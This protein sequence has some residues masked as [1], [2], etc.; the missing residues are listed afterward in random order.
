MQHCFVQTFEVLRVYHVRLL[1]CAG[2]KSAQFWKRGTQPSQDKKTTVK[3]TTAGISQ[4]NALYFFDEDLLIQSLDKSEQDRKQW[5]LWAGSPSNFQ[6][7]NK[8]MRSDCTVIPAASVDTSHVYF[9][10]GGTQTSFKHHGCCCIQDGTQWV[11]LM[12]H[13]INA[14]CSTSNYSVVA[15][16]TVAKDVGSN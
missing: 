16:I 4:T 8:I 13:H 14:S 10:L 7:N 15:Q 9:A 1:S 2:R 11:I 6:A 12:Q 3:I 5:N